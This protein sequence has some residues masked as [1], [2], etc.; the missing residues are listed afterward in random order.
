VYAGVDVCKARSAV[1]SSNPSRRAGESTNVRPGYLEINTHSQA[2][3][4]WFFSKGSS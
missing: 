2:S 3:I 1:R 4:P